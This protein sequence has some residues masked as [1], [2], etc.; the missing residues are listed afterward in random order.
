MGHQLLIPLLLAF[1]AYTHT[2]T[3]SKIELAVARLA[4]MLNQPPGEGCSHIHCRLLL[5]SE[6]QNNNSPLTIIDILAVAEFQL[7]SSRSATRKTSPVRAQGA[8]T[9]ELVM[10]P[11]GP[12]KSVS[13]D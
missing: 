13:L 11:Q 5:D 3:P 12:L 6:L 1:A 7:A 9:E 4:T 10:C 8:A 2:H